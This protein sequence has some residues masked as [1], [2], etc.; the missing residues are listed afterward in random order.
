MRC[1]MLKRLGITPF[2]QPYRDFNA[3]TEPALQQKR[4]ARYVNHKAIFNSID[5]EDYR[6]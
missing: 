4:F 6:G 3:N 2:A 5:W 1:R